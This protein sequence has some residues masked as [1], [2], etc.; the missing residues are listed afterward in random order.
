MGGFAAKQRRRAERLSL[1]RPQNEF[2]DTNK[3]DMRA[4]QKR[5]RTST[6]D[7]PAFRRSP[8]QVRSYAKNTSLQRSGNAS[9]ELLPTKKKNINKPKHLKRKIESISGE[10][11][12]GLTMNLTE[13]EH[14]LQQ[15]E[16]FERRKLKLRHNVQNS[17]K[18]TKKV[19]S[20]TERKNIDKSKLK[21]RNINKVTMNDGQVKDETSARKEL[22][23]KSKPE[24]VATNATIPSTSTS[25][26]SKDTHQVSAT[27]THLEIAS[28]TRKSNKQKEDISKDNSDDDDDT[29]VTNHNSRQRGKRLRRRGAASLQNQKSTEGTAQSQQESDDVVNKDVAMSSDDIPN[30]SDKSSSNAPATNT[31]EATRPKNSQVIT[32]EHKQRRCI[33]RK[34]VTD[35]AVGKYY[36]GNIVYTKPF[37]IFVDIG[38]HYDAFCHVS[39]LSTTFV[40]NPIDTYPVGTKLDQIRIVELDRKK[41]RI[42]IS[43]KKESE[44]GKKEVKTPEDG[45]STVNSH[46][47]STVVAANTSDENVKEDVTNVAMNHDNGNT[48]KKM[49]TAEHLKRDRKLARR[50][51]RRNQRND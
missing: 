25:G 21:T 13:K 4:P 38:C 19:P 2:N 7:S 50:A 27:P 9:T 30:A 42:T 23:T 6:G 14:L 20:I 33:G 51:E 45:P 11:T 10:S 43:L 5:A 22:Q 24:V 29:S 16:E 35:F 44:N 41:K 47:T 18:I 49:S 26:N 34:P 46:D 1:Q 3:Y 48:P 17:P 12:E 8:Q 36:T 28:T 15:L 39:Q 37:G 40:E 32:E 31:N